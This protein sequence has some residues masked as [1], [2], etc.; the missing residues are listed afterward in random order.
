MP[1]RSEQ[2]Q[3]AD[4]AVAKVKEVWTSIGATAEEVQKDYGEDLLVQTCLNNKMDASRLWVQV[5][6]VRSAPGTGKPNGRKTIRVRADLALRWA[7][8]ADVLLL[9]LWDVENDQGWYCLPSFG[10]LHSELAAKTGR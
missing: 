2:H 6:G 9:V 5:K 10:A 3:I 1:I 4:K 7:R 8:T